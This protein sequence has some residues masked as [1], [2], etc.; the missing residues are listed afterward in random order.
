VQIVAIVGL[1]I[2]LVLALILWRRGTSI[3]Y[4]T[5]LFFMLCILIPFY[6]I[7]IQRATPSREITALSSLV[8]VIEIY[9]VSGVLLAITN[10]MKSHRKKESNG[11][12]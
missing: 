3:I 12:Q 4:L 2:N 7:A 5:P 9:I 10:T 8:R 1:F 11:K 6:A